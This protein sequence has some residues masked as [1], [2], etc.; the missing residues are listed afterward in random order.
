[1]PGD[2][3]IVDERGYKQDP[4]GDADQNPQASSPT[5]DQPAEQPTPD[6][7]AAG[8]TAAG[9]PPETVP[10]ARFNEV[11]DKLNKLSSLAPLAELVRDESDI[12]EMRAALLRKQL[13]ISE[14]PATAP[15]S[16]APEPTAADVDKFVEAL[17]PSF[18]ANPV[19]T[20]MAISQAI[21]RQES[22]KSSAPLA[23]L[24]IS[25]AIQNFKAEMAGHPLYKVV[26]PIFNDMVG[27]IPR[28]EFRGKDDSEIR[29]ALASKWSEAAGRA[30]MTAYDVAVREGKI[31]PNGEAP[32]PPNYGGGSGGKGSAKGQFGSLT[33]D[34]VTAGKR[35][36]LTDKELEE[37]GRE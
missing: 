9:K 22:E 15:V 7:R 2:T 33:A 29:R 23:G 6:S 24:V 27:A 28:S 10:L 13:G 5:G 16:A 31:K 20:A 8:D 4:E 37:M 12:H 36:G 21:A 18:A 35:L 3:Q 1:M 34:E 11:N 32:V 30:M 19:K 26:A 17:T 14:K 25:L